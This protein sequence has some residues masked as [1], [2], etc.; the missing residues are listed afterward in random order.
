LG[1]ITDKRNLKVVGHRCKGEKCFPPVKPTDKCLEPNRKWSE[2]KDWDRNEEDGAAFDR[3]LR[4]DTPL[5]Q[6]GDEFIIPPGWNMEYDL[7]DSPIYEM[8]DI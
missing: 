8:I 5:P 6:A 3:K 7:E 2:V 4:K 1:E